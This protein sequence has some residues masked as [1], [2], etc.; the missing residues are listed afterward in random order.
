ML[1]YNSF[2][3]INYDQYKDAHILHDAKWKEAPIGLA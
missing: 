3:Y 1:G 2:S